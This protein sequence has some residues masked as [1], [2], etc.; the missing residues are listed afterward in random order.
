MVLIFRR[1][2]R[3]DIKAHGAKC[4]SS[5]SAFQR[6]SRIRQWQVMAGES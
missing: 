6:S 5:L 3:E 4:R 2:G 1:V